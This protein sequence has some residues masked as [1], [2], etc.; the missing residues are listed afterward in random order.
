MDTDDY[1]I[2]HQPALMHI[3][4]REAQEATTL[5]ACLQ[6]LD[7]ELAMA[8]ES[9]PVGEAE[10]LRLLGRARL[11]A[12][13]AGLIEPHGESDPEDGT[14]QPFQLTERGRLMLRENPMGVDE[15]VL[16]R[17]PDFA[18]QI[19]AQ[20]Q[21][22][23]IDDAAEAQYDMGFAAYRGGKSLADNPFPFDT[24]EHL[25]WENGWFEA[26]DEFGTHG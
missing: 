9:P 14:S 24:V 17:F 22:R 3:L 20:S 7:R 12:A 13:K 2:L 8:K 26:R 25:A 5:E 6:E 15:S 10:K 23:H 4:L 16:M 11:T 19:R 21:D 1:S 18:A